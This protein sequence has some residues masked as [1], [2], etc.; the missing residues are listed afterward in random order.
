MK[1]LNDK[2]SIIKLKLFGW[3]MQNS[4]TIFLYQNC[5]EFKLER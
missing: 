1:F 4:R 3:T 5:S 2:H